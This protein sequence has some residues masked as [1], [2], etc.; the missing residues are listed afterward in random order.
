MYGKRHSVD[1][2]KKMSSVR[3]KYFQNDKNKKNLSE[4]KLGIKNPNH[5]NT[6]KK[7]Y[8]NMENRNKTRF[9]I[10]KYY[11][12]RSE[13]EKV[14]HSIRSKKIIENLKQDKEK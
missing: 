10:N 7:Y 13:V 11:N 6:M 12:N 2:I 8:S 3:I 4:K 14:A 1:S 5:S 9:A